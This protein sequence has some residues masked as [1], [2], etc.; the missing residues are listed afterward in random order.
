MVC[1]KRM[2][3]PNEGSHLAVATMALAC[4][5]IASGQARNTVTKRC[6]SDPF[7]SKL[8]TLPT[9][10]TKHGLEKMERSE[11]SHVSHSYLHV[12]LLL[13]PLLRNFTIA[14]LLALTMR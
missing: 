7:L 1:E 2:R 9:N 14:T 12:L 4:L 10:A 13:P 3:T 6:E 5:L 11:T 8:F